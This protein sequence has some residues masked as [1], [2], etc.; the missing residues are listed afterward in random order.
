MAKLPANLHVINGGLERLLR[1]AHEIS[2]QSQCCLR[3][4]ALNIAVGNRDGFDLLKSDISIMSAILGLFDQYRHARRKC[5]DESQTRTS[6]D[7]K[8]VRASRAH[9]EAFY[10]G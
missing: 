4:G 5:I 8:L 6:G 2:R 10:T 3:D 1:H 7:K 9:H